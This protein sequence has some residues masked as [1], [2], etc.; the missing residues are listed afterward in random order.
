MSEIINNPFCPGDIIV[1]DT[2]YTMQ[3]PHFA[4]VEAITPS[5]KSAR[6]V[7]LRDNF[8]PDDQYGQTGYK[9]PTMEP[10]GPKR[11]CRITRYGSIKIDNAYGYKWGGMPARYDTLD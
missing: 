7:P 9:V 10:I 5:G 4:L 11:T 3:L 2:G 1:Y 8:T 6:I